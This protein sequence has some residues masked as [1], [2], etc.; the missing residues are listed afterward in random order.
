MIKKTKKFIVLAAMMAL[1][2]GLYAQESNLYKVT[3]GELTN[4]GDNFLDVGGW[5][6]L[7]AGM[8]NVFVFSRLGANTNRGILNLGAGLKASNLY[9]GLYYDGD[10]TAANGQAGVGRKVSIGEGQEINVGFTVK[11]NPEATYAAFLGLGGVGIKFSFEDNL[12]LSGS[13]VA[14]VFTQVSRGDLIPTFTISGAGAISYF[15][16]ALPIH[17]NRTE[18][19]TVNPGGYTHVA[20]SHDGTLANTPIGTASSTAF[21][22]V[23]NEEA[24][25]IAIQPKIALSFGSFKLD[26]EL[27]VPIFGISAKTEENKGGLVPG[28]G[29]STTTYTSVSGGDTYRAVWDSRFAITNTLTPKYNI[30]NTVGKVN[31]SVTGALPFILGLTTHS[32]QGKAVDAAGKVTEAKGFETRSDFAIGIAPEIT[33][34]IQFKPA[35]FFSLQAGL[36]LT[37]F[38]LGGIFTNTTVKGFA[39]GSTDESNAQAFG[40]LGTDKDVKTSS[41]TS[42]FLYPDL[43]CSLGF[44][45][46]IKAV[47]IDFAFVQD[48]HPALTAMVYEGVAATLGGPDASIVLTAKF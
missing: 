8:K 43:I 23:A 33:A 32:A 17:Y 7:S 4:D 46:N 22:A 38:T 41:S 12:E 45:F 21:F 24:N 6:D 28:V 44:T 19:T 15:Q 5:K 16:L 10:I 1:G 29:S 30:S 47:T 13:A 39:T 2:L 25:Y 48:L 27:V 34:G 14:P 42:S 26:E 37:L 11:D 36:D 35:D 31:F 40:W 18:V 20:Q 9:L 3:F